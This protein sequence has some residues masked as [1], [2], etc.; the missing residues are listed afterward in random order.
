MSRPRWDVEGR[1]WPNR[2][3]SRFVDVGRMRFHVQIMGDGPVLLLLHGTGAA[4]HSWRAL[5][6]LLAEQATVIAPDLPG[7]GFTTGRPAGGMGIIAMARAVGELLEVLEIRPQA[8]AGH[9][10]G[11]AIAVRTALD[12]VADPA[13]II[14]LN[15]ALLP[16]PGL[17]AALFP[18]L[19]RL[20]FVNPLA[21]HILSRLM[22]SP[23]ETAR[24]L[25]RSTGSRIDQQGVRCYERLFATSDH[26]AGAIGM[27]ADWDLEAL[28]RDLPRL[29]T[30]LLLVHGE[31]DAAIPLATARGAAAMVSGA[32]LQTLPRLGHLAHEEQPSDI[33]VI[34][35]NFLEAFL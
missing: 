25:A 16:F 4:T 27:M 3:H 29:H 1:D 26:C 15:A 17:A 11:A 34:I 9:S 13:A 22:R 12:G 33:A 18:T 8:M 31:A 23:G 7:H 24:F 2:A 5:A 20:L 32:Q 30:P 19:A 28:K 35:R 6:P 14:G 10:A 21:P